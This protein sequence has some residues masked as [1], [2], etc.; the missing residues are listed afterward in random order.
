VVGSG[1]KGTDRGQHPDQAAHQGRAY[2]P[3]NPV[4]RQRPDH[5]SLPPLLYAEAAIPQHLRGPHFGSASWPLPFEAGL[6]PSTHRK[7]KGKGKFK[8]RLGSTP[9]AEAYPKKR[10]SLPNPFT[11]TL[12]SQNLRLIGAA[13][14]EKP[15]L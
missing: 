15:L 6:L 9:R 3:Q 8:A 4:P 1:K 2:L 5:L 11:L 10:L 14:L 13:R 12:A 7:V